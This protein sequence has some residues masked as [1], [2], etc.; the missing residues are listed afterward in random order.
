[1]VKTRLAATIGK[2]QA[3][4]AYKVLLRALTV[5][6]AEMQNVVVE[7]SPPQ[8]AA[9]LEPFFPTHWQFAPQMGIDL[10]ERLGNAFE[11]AF[12]RDARKV[13]IIGSDCPYIMPRDLLETWQQLETADV[14]FGPATDGGYWLVALK[15]SAAG[16][17]TGIP[18]GTERVLE[19]STVR[20]QEMN[21]RVSLLRPLPDIDTAADWE[22]FCRRPLATQHRA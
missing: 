18:W 11:A 13:A 3:C 14:V 16:F 5:Q 17:F 15:R 20:A 8:A 1:M 22:E 9:E 2:E 12:R 4:A 21:L 6:L 10:G 7:H 19:Q